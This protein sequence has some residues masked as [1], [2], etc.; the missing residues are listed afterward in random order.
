MTTSVPPLTILP[1]SL[2]RRIWFEDISLEL[3][4]SVGEA[5]SI[6][7]RVGLGGQ[8]G[9]ASSGEYLPFVL[10]EL[11]V[12]LQV[13][14]SR[15]GESI[16]YKTCWRLWEA[17]GFGMNMLALRVRAEILEGGECCR[18]LHLS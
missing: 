7:V 10:H 2:E 4:N 16:T 8:F 5:G 14:P 12:L 1:T 15:E 11:W 3:K 13:G 18:I 17:I 9:A 6:V